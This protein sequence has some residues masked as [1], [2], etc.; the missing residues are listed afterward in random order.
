MVE[1]PTAPICR[2][3]RHPIRGGFV[4]CPTCG[5]VYHLQCARSLGCIC[6]E[7]DRLDCAQ[8]LTR[9][10]G[11][12]EQTEEPE[13]RGWAAPPPLPSPQP[14]DI[15]ALRV[16]RVAVVL[17][18]AGLP[19]LVWASLMYRFGVWS[20]EA[21]LWE[22]LSIVLIL[23]ATRREFRPLTELP[24]GKI[25]VLISLLYAMLYLLANSPLLKIL[26]FISH[27]ALSAMIYRQ[28]KT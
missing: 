7:G 23:W 12:R 4:R 17:L 24:A 22:L 1:Q 28:A 16:A 25:L 6:I 5:S 27:T 3:C 15:P 11:G 2:Y 10:P 19:W 8:V 21:T 26:S 9:L 14:V 13:R 20:W 18:L